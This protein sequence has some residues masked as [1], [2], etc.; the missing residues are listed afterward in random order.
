MEQDLNHMKDENNNIRELNNKSSENLDKVKRQLSSSEQLL[1]K[2]E[3]KL[4]EYNNRIPP[5]IPDNYKDQKDWHPSFLQGMW[6]NEY[7]LHCSR[8]MLT[9]HQLFG[10]PRWRGIFRW[11]L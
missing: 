5:V 1:E 4:A 10:S 8:Y 2:Y 9:N 3:N 7:S 6:L 11:V